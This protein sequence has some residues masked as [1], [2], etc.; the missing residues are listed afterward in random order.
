MAIKMNKIIENLLNNPPKKVK[1][2]TNKGIIAVAKAKSI[3]KFSI[4]EFFLS[5]FFF[6]TKFSKRR[7]NSPT[8]NSV[9][10]KIAVK[11]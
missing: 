9:A 1:N 7:A 2:I 4:K 8:V 11:K 10:K 6:I 3:L 5:S